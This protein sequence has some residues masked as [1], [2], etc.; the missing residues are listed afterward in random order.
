M[1]ILR[2]QHSLVESALAYAG[3]GWLV[4]VL[5]GVQSQGNRLTCDCHKGRDCPN[6]G[7]HP[8]AA[9]WQTLAT[10]DLNTI[11]G[12]WHQW[13]TSNVGILLGR[14]SG[15]VDVEGDSPEA[16]IESERLL[17]GLRT[18]CYRSNRSVHRLFRLPPELVSSST[19]AKVGNLELRLGTPKAAQSVVPPSLHASGIRYA[20]LPG[21]S[22]DDCSPAAF[23]PVLVE[24]M[25]SQSLSNRNGHATDKELSFTMGADC[26]DL[27]TAP[28]V[29]EGDRHKQLCRLVGSHLA[30]F[31]PTPELWQLAYVWAERC[32]P[33]LPSDEVT[34]TVNRLAERET[35]KRFNG[36]TTAWTAQQA[37]SP[38]IRPKVPG[39]RP[40]PTD[41]LL[42]PLRGL[43]LAGSKAI[44]CDPSFIALPA[45][46]AT[47]AM[48]GNSRRIRLKGNWTEPAILWTAIVGY[49]GDKKTPAKMLA[50]NPVYELQREAFAEATDQ[51]AKY[52]EAKAR[53]ELELT[54]WKRNPI[55]D[56]PTK[57]APPIAR[58]V[59]VSDTTVE[60]L[61][62]I[63]R[64][65]VH[66]VLLA[67]DELD[68]WFGSFDR[69]A[70]GRGSDIPNWLSIHNALPITV[71][72]KSGGT[73]FVD[74]AAVSICGGIQPRILRK[75]MRGV[76][77]DSGML[78]RFV[79]AM[80]P[81]T[82]TGWT[83]ATVEP[84]VMAHYASALDSLRELGRD[85]WQGEA[86]E[87]V[88][89]P[90]SREGLQLFKDHCNR[91]A[92]ERAVAND[93]VASVL[94][95]LE[96]AAARLALIFQC[97]A[98][99]REPVSGENMR[100]GVDLADWFGHEAQRIFG[101][102]DET[103]VDEGL[104]RL[105]EW[106][107]GRGG[108]ITARE[109]QQGRRDV[110]SAAEAEQRLMQLASSG[111][112]TFGFEHQHTGRPVQ[113]FRLHEASTSTE[114]EKPREKTTCVDVD[115]V[116]GSQNEDCER[117]WL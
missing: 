78:A 106:I 56:P 81:R 99:P 29:A 72:R 80:P 11:E 102:A 109:L 39:Y 59:V 58:R 63:L 104:R 32:H 77:R 1:D 17:G 44:G 45:L 48:L 5:H 4:V 92:D 33:P 87:P 50:L 88:E 9:A 103:P 83:D 13:P 19:V 8:R 111:Y 30:R 28:G 107:A 51:A 18:P 53:Y 47:A 43:V 82:K 2:E 20:W 116:D 115:S 95:K 108:R 85:A 75:S 90:L 94:S 70:S 71:D 110:T 15:V 21:L 27:A 74:R 117:G 49:S 67:R 113:V 79:Y 25:Q 96:A 60:A 34:K 24:L 76:L 64:D 12:W 42:E 114:V 36:T 38:V 52:E 97:L 93:D 3:R 69:Y 54:R 57:P 14:A 66:G 23:P 6:P 37:A 22:P 100:R 41:V 7:K 91:L 98:N 46:A 105:A 35:A 65:N 101:I 73:I 16:Q 10:T 84:S 31:G 61:A 40:F 112:G 55:G 86:F 62:P 68:G 26:D 89:L